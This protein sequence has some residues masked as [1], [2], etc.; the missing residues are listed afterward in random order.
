[1]LSHCPEQKSEVILWTKVKRAT[2]GLVRRMMQPE[3]PCFGC[4]DLHNKIMPGKSD[5]ASPHAC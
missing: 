1:M 5:D 4:K 3:S 2:R